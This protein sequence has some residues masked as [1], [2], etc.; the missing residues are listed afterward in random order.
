ME[1]II[2][3]CTVSF[4]DN[5]LE[6]FEDYCWSCYD[7]ILENYEVKNTNPQWNNYKLEEEE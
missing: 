5:V 4:C 2:K 7:R 3:N 1:T 6:D